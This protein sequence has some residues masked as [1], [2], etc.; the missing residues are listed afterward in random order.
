M[1]SEWP[2]VFFDLKFRNFLRVGSELCRTPSWPSSQNFPSTHSGEESA[3]PGFSTVLPI[4]IMD[5]LSADTDASALQ[6]H[7]KDPESSLS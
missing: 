3:G 7:L 5:P 1:N 6:L 4:E 2:E